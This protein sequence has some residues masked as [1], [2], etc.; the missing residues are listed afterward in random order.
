MIRRSPVLALWWHAVSVEGANV[1]DEGVMARLGSMTAGCDL[2]LHSDASDG[3]VAAA[4]LATDLGHV[5]MAVLTDHDTLAGS[6]AFAQALDSELS[7]PDGVELSLRWSGG[8]F[9]LLVY[10]YSLASTELALRIDEL[11]MARRNRNLEL[12]ERANQAGLEITEAEVLAAAGTTDFLAKSVG[13]PHFAKVLV[14]RGYVS[15]I[16][17]AF[18][19]YLAKGRPLYSPKTLFGL[20]EIGPLCADLGLVAV[21]AH[22]LSLGVPLTSLPDTLAK[23]QRQGLAGVECY[24]AGY[25]PQQRV[26]LAQLASGLKLLI[27]GGSDYHGSFKPGLAALSGFGDLSVAADIGDRLIERL[28][29]R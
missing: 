16:Q 13:R 3:S 6:E 17:D 20:E 22:P 10:G 26:E 5:H 2:H 19:T 23:F 4:Q 29:D 9:H 15:S 28:H 11:A 14:D 24:Y 27:T 25:S 18:D 21:I 12:L 8:T 1:S 7:P